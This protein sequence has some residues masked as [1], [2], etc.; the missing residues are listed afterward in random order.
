MVY[1]LVM[2]VLV[3]CV[4][5]QSYNR[6]KNYLRAECTGFFS[7]LKQMFKSEIALMCLVLLNLCLMIIPHLKG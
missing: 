3:I 6:N 5:I 4:L 1:D 7:V 2:I